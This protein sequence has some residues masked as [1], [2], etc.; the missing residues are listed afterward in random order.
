MKKM[1]RLLALVMCAAITMM[2]FAACGTAEKNPTDSDKKVLKVGV[3]QYAVHG[4]LD[5][6]YNGFVQGLKEA[7]FEDG[8]NIEIDYQNANSKQ[9]TSEQIAKNMAA[10]RYDLIVGIATPSAL[11]AYAAARGTSIP[12]LFCAV[13]DP[14]RSE[15]VQ[16]LENPGGNTTGTTDLLN[17]EAQLKMIRA[18]QPEAK[19]IGVIYTTSEPNS[20]THLK[21]FEELAPK[22]GFEIV[23]QGIQESSDIPQAAA[24][25]CS[26]VDCINNFTDNN[27]VQNLGVL[28]A[29]ADEA[30]I[31]VY[32]SEIEQVEKGCLASE[33]LDYIALGKKT[34]EQAAKILNGEKAGSIPVEKIQD[35]IPVYNEE[36]MKKL[37]LTLPAEYASAQ[38]VAA[39]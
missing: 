20:V 23:P 35:S 22:Y 15:L 31:P 7:G 13:S 39:K 32:G 18:F 8:K 21:K 1:K 24:T 2:T 10:K 38:N 4:S 36:V 34:G 26:K 6:C 17:L 37:G 9:E 28:L 33:S 12:T 19:K 27:L 30:G 16:S 14:V 5:N 11:S 25:L 29:K 3:I